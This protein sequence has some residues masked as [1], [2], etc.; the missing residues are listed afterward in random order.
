MVFLFFLSCSL[1]FIDAILLYHAYCFTLCFSCMLLDYHCFLTLQAVSSSDDM[2]SKGKV[3]DVA[4]AFG[5]GDTV[6]I[7][8]IFSE[9]IQE[10]LPQVL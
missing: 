8:D 9:E 10:K 6:S 2:G 4:N 7:G 5:A 1:A 3:A